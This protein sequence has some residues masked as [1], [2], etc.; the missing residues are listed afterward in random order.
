MLAWDQAWDYEKS[1]FI[2][3]YFRINRFKECPLKLNAEREREGGGEGGG[4]DVKNIKAMISS[5]FQYQTAL[6]KYLLV[7]SHE[8]NKIAGKL[9]IFDIL[10]GTIAIVQRT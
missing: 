9:S 7:Y 3:M 6:K 8:K 1:T 10:M 5:Q 4:R 2:I